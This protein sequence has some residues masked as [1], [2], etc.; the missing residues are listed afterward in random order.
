MD[1]GQSGSSIASPTSRPSPPPPFVDRVPS[2]A[3]VSTP[4]AGQSSSG[5]TRP[6]AED[7]IGE[8]QAPPE[9]ETVH[10]TGADMSAP[11]R[12]DDPGASNMGAVTDKS[13]SPKKP[14]R[15]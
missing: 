13:K 3:R 11:E 5:K 8:R 9:D 12:D 15:H 10:N 2:P 4:P 1:V 7:D 14:E 6:E